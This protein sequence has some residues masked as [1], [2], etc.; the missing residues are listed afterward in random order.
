MLVGRGT[1]FRSTT[2]GGVGRSVWR[3]CS[4]TRS[5]RCWSGGLGAQPARRRSR[6]AAGSCWR[7]RGESSQGIAVRLG[8][9]TQTVGRWR[10]RF[11]GRGLDGLHDQPRPG[12]PRLTDDDHV[13]RVIVKTL[14]EQPPNAPPWSTRSMAVATGYEPDCGQPDLAGAGLKAP[15]DAG[16]QALL[17]RAVH[18]QGL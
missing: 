9:S 12:T 17:E 8:C 6:C 14:E 18:R 11:A 2:M 7:R 1:S 10:G 5:E 15:P 13:E 4:A 16:V 3:L